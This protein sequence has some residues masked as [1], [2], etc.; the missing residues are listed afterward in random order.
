MVVR[1]MGVESTSPCPWVKHLADTL[2]NRVNSQRYPSIYEDWRPKIVE[3]IENQTVRGM[4]QDNTA[5]G[6]STGPRVAAT[7][8]LAPTKSATGFFGEN[9]VNDSLPCQTRF[10]QHQ[11]RP[12]C[13]KSYGGE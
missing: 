13:L 1:Y 12:G 2:R 3:D 5:P 10:E 4:L 7:P 6:S 11:E 9:W 8:G